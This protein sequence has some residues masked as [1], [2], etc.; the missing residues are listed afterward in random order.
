MNPQ[1]A[2]E[3]AYHQLELQLDRAAFD[4]WL[5]DAVFLRA[6]S[7]VFVVGVRN[8]Y[9]RDMLQHRLYRGIRRVLSDVCQRPIELQFE[10]F[11]ALK[12]EGSG[13]DDDMPLFRLLA[14][15]EQSTAPVPLHQQIA[16]PQRSD[17]PESELNPRYTFDRFVVGTENEMVFQA[18]LAVTERPATAYNPFFIYGDVGLGKTHLLQAVAHACLS[19]SLRTIY[20]PSEVFTNDLIDSIRQRSTAMFR[21][22]YRSA[23]VLLIDDIQFIAGKDSTQEEFF[24]TFNSLYLNGKQIVIASDRHPRELETLE[25][26][27]RSRFEGGLV[28][29]VQPPSQETRIAILKSWARERNVTLDPRTYELIATRTHMNVRELEGLFNQMVAAAH[30][31]PRTPVRVEAA[32]E[33]I[34]NYRRPRTYVTMRRVVEAVADHHNLLADDLIGPRR[35]GHINNARQIAMYL[36]REMTGASLQQIGDAF[37]RKHSTV[38]HGCNKVTEDIQADLVTRATVEEIRKR[39]QSGE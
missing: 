18:A 28:M 16:R 8:S 15:Q 6:E 14:Q 22:K 38:L 4:T 2:W 23:D 36:A 17:L 26:R 20:I 21:E 3:T 5:R 10:V 11:H 12:T 35:D 33:M 30:L 7:D 25:A 13:G 32:Q 37:G 39:L 24:H 27:L 19:R 29:D 9:A 31:S 34:D 1:D